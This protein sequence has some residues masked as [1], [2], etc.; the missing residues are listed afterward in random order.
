MRAHMTFVHTCFA[1]MHEGVATDPSGRPNRQMPHPLAHEAG[2][3]K[4]LPVKQK[5]RK[6][7]VYK[8]S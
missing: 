3:V 5:M 1:R 8:K 7:T 4:V 2:W 6:K